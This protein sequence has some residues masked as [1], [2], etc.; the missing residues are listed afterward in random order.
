ME[1]IAVEP[2]PPP[3]LHFAMTG[4]KFEFQT[5]AKSGDGVFRFR[6]TLA[7][8]KSGPPEHVH[9]RERE[10]FAV[11]SGTLRIWI[12]DVASDLGPGEQVTVP[13][14]VRHRFL[15]PD[16]VAAVVDVSLDGSLQEDLLVPLA[17][18]FG[19]REQIGFAG[20]CVLVVH[21]GHVRASRSVSRVKEATFRGLGHLFRALGVRPLP[22]AGAW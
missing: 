9:E 6:W 22:P 12:E 4:E 17:Y 16:S 2:S 7:A 18:R 20:F 15:N 10:T 19:G 14:G 21:D 3:V 11:V 5:S 8:G 13:A 1:A